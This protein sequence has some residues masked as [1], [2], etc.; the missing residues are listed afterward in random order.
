[1]FIPGIQ[2]F[3]KFVLFMMAFR[4]LF[5]FIFFNLSQSGL[6]AQYRP[7]ARESF[8][9]SAYKSG[10]WLKFRV[11]YGIFNAS[12]ATLHLTS[13]TIGGTPVY[14]VVGIGKTTG[15][16]SIFFKVDDRY[17]SYFGKTDSRPYRFIRK[18]DEGGYTRDVEINFDYSKKK[19]LY[20]DKKKE[21]IMQFDIGYSIQDLISAFY[22]LRNAYEASDLVLGESLELRVLFDDDGIF[23]F[24]LKYLGTE[25]LKT[26]FGNVECLKFRPFVQSGRVF[27]EEESLSLWVSNDK[28]KIPIRIQADLTVGSIK[29]DLE[30]YNS[31]KNQFRINIE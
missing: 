5:A 8:K 2:I 10:E 18:I 16:A 4:L 31:L 17:E 25:T 1:V 24:R 30:A 15:L 3:T 28:N 27:K 13:D 9:E 23:T 26:K 6:Q 12:S 22:Y 7:E 19:A 14:H 20:H 11:H 21:K 29:A